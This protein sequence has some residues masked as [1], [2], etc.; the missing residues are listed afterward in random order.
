MVKAAFAAFQRC[1]SPRSVATRR[2]KKVSEL[3]ARRETAPPASP[4]PEAPANA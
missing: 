4:A 3:F 1:A 2:G